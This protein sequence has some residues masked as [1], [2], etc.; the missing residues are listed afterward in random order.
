MIASHRT[1]G[2]LCRGLCLA[3]LAGASGCSGEDRDEDRQRAEPTASATQRLGVTHTVCASGCDFPSPAACAIGPGV[4]NGDICLVKGGEYHETV[5]YAAGALRSELIFR[6]EA[7]TRCLIDGDGIRDH[8]FDGYDDWVIEGFEL[9][10]TRVAAITGY[11]RVAA[12]RNCHIHDVQG[13]G[14]EK[15]SGRT[16]APAITGVAENNVVVNTWNHGILCLA[17]PY[18]PAVV[19]NNLVVDAALSGGRPIECPTNT[20]VVHNTVDVRNRTAPYSNPTPYGLQGAT[21]R[22]NVVSGG[23]TSIRA[24][25]AR[26][27]NLAW[28]WGTGAYD[29]SSGTADGTDAT[30]NPLFFG[31]EDY[32]LQA[33]SPARDTAVSSTEALDIT[34]GARSAPPDKG[35]YE[36]ASGHLA[37]TPDWPVRETAGSPATVVSPSLVVRPGQGGGPAMAWLDRTA[38]TIVYAVRRSDGT[39]KQE[40]VLSNHTFPAGSVDAFHHRVLALGI[41]P[42]SGL[43]VIA[44]LK[45]NAGSR[46]LRYAKRTGDACGSGCTS[47]QWTGCGDAPIKTFGSTVPSSL[48]LAFHPTTQQPAIALW[49]S[50]A[51][52]CGGSNQGNRIW[53]EQ[54]QANGTWTESLVASNVPGCTGYIPPGFGLSFHPSTGD[55]EVVFTR[56]TGTGSFDVINAKGELVV[57]SNSGGAFSSQVVP[58]G[59]GNSTA[60]GNYSHAAISH[61]AN[62][63]AAVAVQALF[64]TSFGIGYSRRSAGTWPDTLESVRLLGV[65][66]VEGIDLAFDGTGAPVLA[67]TGD[68]APWIGRR[69][70]TRWDVRVVDAQRETGSW[71][72][73][74]L[75]PQGE[76]LL[77][78]AQIAPDRSVKF[79][80]E[81]LPGGQDP[82]FQDPTSCDLCPQDPNKTAPGTCGCGYL[83]NPS[84]SISDASVQEGASGSTMLAFKVSTSQPCGN[85][86]SFTHATSD[87]SAVAGSDY[88][89]SS[90]TL[91][92]PP[93]ANDTTVSITVYGDTVYEPDETF[94]VTLSNP[95]TGAIADGQATGTILN[96]DNGAPQASGDSVSTS[97]DTPVNFD[98]TANDTDPNGDDLDVVSVSTPS[99]G[100]AALQ[101]DGTVTYTPTADYYGADSF[102]YTVQDGKGGS[103]TAT[104]TVTI[105][106]VNDLPIAVNDSGIVVAGNTVIVPVISNDT[107]VDVDPLGVVSVTQ[108]AVG[109]AAVS[110]QGSVS[111]QAPTGFSG[112]VSFTYT[113]SDGKGG[114]A[115]GTVTIVVSA[116]PDAGADTGVQEEAGVDAEADAPAE[117]DAMPDDAPEEDAGPEQDAAAD[118]SPEDVAQ[119]P[120]EPDSTVQQDVVGDIAPDA[121][122][123]VTPDLAIEA[124][125]E[126]ALD[127][128]TD[129][130]IEAAPEAAIDVASDVPVDVKPDVPADVAVEAKADAAAGGSGGA[131]G[132]TTAPEGPESGD[133][134]GC[135]CRSGAADSERPASWF[136]LAAIGLLGVLRRRRR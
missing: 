4:T 18:G 127:V 30:G 27:E 109:T 68:R 112:T 124:A 56:T 90:G 10:G 99:H 116:L 48:R 59:A 72:S 79:Q 104:V 38:N 12:V 62:G 78:H 6:C 61:A 39:W 11:R 97:E 94:L 36:Y 14:I 16:T 7:G 85:A 84:L 54:R 83:D 70:P 100:T 136:A 93:G 53:F 35:A 19:K 67:F 110:G 118:V 21:V 113:V 37:N 20:T 40:T 135:A 119:D 44:Y 32:F 134:G 77:G 76:A 9:T 121:A 49:Q 75:T 71:P 13:I 43:P 24:T 73:L 98:P 103:S 55:A 88:V 123:D 131:A 81:T 87:Q 114:T 5:T 8:A 34:G 28:A 91:S 130:A 26:G 125:P 80:S 3:L 29:T 111:Y 132:G 126:A 108:P 50:I 115:V 89:A 101:P 22:Y 107:D 63:D 102:Q 86:I 60:G 66:G 128:A 46:E 17:S 42:S 2:V 41:E 57:A 106:A 65:R 47:P 117:A 95:S 15:L 64:G 1:T 82:A 69:L 129:V 51:S 133:D 92:I 52:E 33:G 120:A 31:L 45:I 74:R 25:V 23:V 122:L 96:D 58:L 105:A